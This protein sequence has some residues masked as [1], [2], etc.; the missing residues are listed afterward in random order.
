MRRTSLPV[1]AL[2]ATAVTA[3]LLTG[4]PALA[5]AP[6]T[7]PILRYALDETSGTVARDSSGAG[8]DGALVGGAAA[9]GSAGVRLDGVDDAVELPDDVL[10]GLSS[11]SVSVEVLVRPEQ[12]G[13]YFVW[14]MGTPATSSS[15]DGYLGTLADATYRTTITP[16]NWSG[17]RSADSGSA[18]A[19][20]AWSTLT[21]TLDD[22]SD[23]ARLYL[24]GRQVAEQDGVTV[25]PG[26]IGGGRTTANALGRSPYASDRTLA[27]S[28]RELRVYDRALGAGEVAALTPTDDARVSRDADALAVDG[29]DA[30]TADL[31]LPAAGVNGSA[32]TWASSSPAIAADGT[33][34]R[35][36]AGQPDATV[37]LTATL[38]R[39]SAVATRELV[40]TVPAARTD[41]QAA[42]AAVA[43]VT[44]PGLDD[45]R[46]N[47]TLPTEAQGASVA[48][49]SSDPGVVDATGVVRRQSDART[50][51]L[52][53]R[54]TV[55]SATAT[56]ELSAAVRPSAQLGALEG[57]AFAYF[58]GNTVDGEKVRF[59]AS[60]GNDA[61]KWDELDGGKPRLTSTEGT[62]GLRDPFLIRSPEGD[63]FYLIATDLSIGGGTSWDASQ[64]QGSRYLEVW[65]SHDLVNW[66]DQR[67]VLV[68]PPEAGNTWAPEA[69]YDESIGAYV[70]FW[71]S[72][73]YAA[74]DPGHT[75]D[76][77]NSMLYATTRDF[78]TFTEPQVW[79][80]GTSRIDSTV[81]ERDGVYHRFT[82]DEGAAT[83]CSDII[84][85]R[86]TELRA[87]LADWT[88]EDSCIGRD[89]GTSAVEGPT[90]FTA[91]P[92][93]VNGPADY[94]FVDEYGGRGY[95]PLRTDDVAAPDWEVAP[96]AELPTS[97][98]HGTVLPV[99]AAE[100]AALRTGVDAPPTPVTPNAR[101]ELL[102]YD[103]QG[104]SGSTVR[105]VSGNGLDGTIS[106]G[107]AWEDDA[108]V[109][110]GVDD[111][112][113]LPDDV[114]AGRDAISV[115]AQVW[116][117]PAQRTP[118]F[119]YGLGNSTGGAGDGYLFTT[120]D[121]YRTSIASGNWTTEQTASSGQ[122]LPRGRWAA[123]MYTLE[124]GTATLHLDGEVVATRTGVTTTPGSLGGGRTAAN[125][126][127]RSLYDADQPFQGRFREFALY[128]RALDQDEVLAAAG[129]VDRITGVSLA[130]ASQLRTAPLVDAQ[131]RTVSFPVQPGTPLTAL[132]PTFRLPAGATSSPASGTVRDLS[133]PVTYAITLADGSRVD[134][135]MS[136]LVMRSPVLP[137]FNADP[138][139]RVFGDT[140]Y[141]YPTT[142]GVPGWGGK[143]LYVWSSKDLVTWER[144]AEPILTLDGAAGNVPWAT[145]NAWAPTAIEKG[146]KYYLY[147]SGHSAALDRKAIGVAVADSPTGPFVAQPEP[148][149]TN[150]EAV[151]SG[152]A[153]DPAAFTDPATGRSHLFW[154]NGEP[155]AA[156]LSDDMLSIR[157]DT[158][159]RVDGLTDFREGSFVNFRDGLYHLTY[160][161]DDTGSPEYRTG[162]ATATSIDGPWTAHGAILAKRPELGILATGHSSI[163]NVPGT[164]DWYI[165]YHRFAIPGGDGTHRETT[166]DRVT[167]DPATGL[168]RPVTPTLTS[169]DPQRVPTEPPAPAL[170]LRTSAST[171]R[172][173]GR[174]A[175]TVTTT[176]ASDVPVRITQSTAFGERV[177]G[178]VAPGRSVK[179]VFPTGARAI[180]AG[181]VRVTG[182]ATVAG[183]PVTTETTTAYAAAPTPVL[184]TRATA[185]CTGG[186]VVVTVTTTNGTG[187]PVT[188]VQSTSQ[189]TA[190]AVLVAAGRSTSRAFATGARS[191]PAG[192]ATATG[193]ATIDGIV[194]EGSRTAAYRATACR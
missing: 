135:T 66:S 2:T 133:S 124:D 107:A 52:T 157:Q 12:T 142:D 33:V 150:G 79:Q 46:G 22:A 25:T 178:P 168:M 158:L 64:R 174:V 183:E 164:D 68:S 72:K 105:D 43:A 16:G 106:G 32:I 149:I 187:V 101:G 24:D 145:G 49:T 143:E 102:R 193:T 87:P 109:F 155:L 69:F 175:I 140:Y 71:A 184:T 39:G 48:W 94:L 165:A 29:L 54:A 110:D 27:G 134:W 3:S 34:T 1:A 59:A 21:Y 166:I 35:P 28:V 99:T 125:V 76:T 127:G 6:D 171:S 113:D 67:H 136:A 141:I 5:A 30:V 75:G 92:G 91:N 108:L 176:N 56:R 96:D 119:L 53:A 147:F 90:A 40:A 169:V 38:R 95:I 58:T 36:T 83:G 47:L 51:T 57:Y 114:L 31:A 65:E 163:V 117:D 84:Q 17:E 80:D 111:R 74:D 182:T 189:G 9:S 123:L 179:R 88:I 152:Q 50:V 131:A 137:G 15:G 78:T 144:S 85:E 104:G 63:T 18:L 188:V 151:T 93:D 121:A 55:G 11:I 60:R 172:I 180:A 45:V 77:A 122:P 41:Q 115:E 98:R 13:P 73:L 186:Q 100:L 81:I 126:L 153:I 116:I 160:A 148:M 191:I 86:S 14:G 61:L 190:P 173:G 161:I 129:V 8:R 194:V 162:Y 82:K 159:H 97:P 44:V 70:V 130:D 167:F 181:E 185:R 19:R 62:T 120:G 7:G 118:Y 170:D 138:D 42:E 103:F 26:S 10:A 4:G 128:D 37:T 146:G 112:V 192:T 156:E 132:A 154:G 20:G 139:I 23:T 89:A 177:H